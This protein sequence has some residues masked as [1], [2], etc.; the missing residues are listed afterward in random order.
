MLKRNS[1]ITGTKPKL[2]DSAD[3]QSTTIHLLFC[4]RRRGDNT[5][6]AANDKIQWQITKSEYK[7]V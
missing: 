4:I 6:G 1:D 7:S 3:K 5:Q 2:D